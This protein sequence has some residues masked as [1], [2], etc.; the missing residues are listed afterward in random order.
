MGNKG[1][2]T[3]DEMIKP[4]SEMLKVSCKDGK[5]H[6]QNMENLMFIFDQIK[7]SAESGATFVKVGIISEYSR[8]ILLEKGYRVTDGDRLDTIHWD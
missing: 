7:K 1:Y 5:A 6:D 8:S 2:I 4:A 3:I